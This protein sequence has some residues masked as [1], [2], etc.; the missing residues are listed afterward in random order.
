MRITEAAELYIA[1]NVYQQDT[2]DTLNR[3]ARLFETRS[4]CRSIESIDLV[5]IKTFRDETLKVAKPVTYNGYLRYLKLLSKW[6][7]DEEYVQKDW[8]SKVKSATLPIAPPKTVD[9]DVFLKAI[10]Y[11]KTDSGA[12]QP[13]WFWLI[14]IRFLYFTGVRRRQ[15]VAIEYQDLDLKKQVLTCSYRGSKTY[16]EW[17]IPIAD[18]LIPDLEYLIRRAE[19]ELGRPMREGDRLFNVCLFYHRYKPDP[20]NNGAMRREHV[21][22]FMR[23]LSNKIG[24]RIGAHRIRHTTATVL[25]NPVDEEHEPDIFSVQKLLGHTQLSTTRNYV[26]TKIGRIRTQVNR[27]SLPK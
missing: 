21:T 15:L 8:F 1:L 13:A 14:V 2:A 22:G 4:G 16:R 24:Q 17:D 3:V 19:D 7:F 23:R 20:K 11:L 18:D 9:D 5:A 25:C 27:M 10:T 6:L 26:K 12:P